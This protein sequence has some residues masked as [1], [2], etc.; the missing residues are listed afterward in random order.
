VQCVCVNVLRRKKIR[1]EL[2]KIRSHVAVL[3][4]RKAEDVNKK[5]VQLRKDCRRHGREV[6]QESL[7]MKCGGWCVEDGTVEEYRMNT[8]A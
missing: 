1:P 6:V 8:G 2:G 3:A 7:Q 5:A 4:G